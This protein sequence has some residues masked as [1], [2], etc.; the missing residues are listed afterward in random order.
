MLSSPKPLGGIQLN[1]LHHFSFGL[2]YARATLFFRVSV[3]PS[4]VHLSV[5]QFPPKPVGGIQSNLQ[6][7]W[8]GCARVTLFFSVSVRPSFVHLSVTLSLL[9]HWRTL[10][11]LLHHFPSLLGCARATLFFRASVVRPFVRHAVS[12][13]TRH[14]TEFN[15]TCYTTSPHV[16]G[17]REQHYF[18]VCPFARRSSICLSRY[19]LLNHRAGFNQTCYITSP[20]GKGVQ[21]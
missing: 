1:W 12:S 21:D 16:L 2:G 10:T 14:W 11:N 9:N 19:L 17:V 6:P 8:L 15:Q 5:T 13:L 18:S 7:S 20:H 4:T 3:R